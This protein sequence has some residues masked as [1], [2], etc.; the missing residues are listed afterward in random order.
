MSELHRQ[1]PLLHR[2]RRGL[3]AT[4]GLAAAAS[5]L[6]LLGLSLAQIVA[7]NL[8]DAGLPW[9]E[10]ASRH[11]VLYVLFFGALLAVGSRRH[12]K[13]DLLGAW[14]S[15]HRQAR[16]VRPLSVIAAAVC[17]MLG[18]AAVRY[19]ID[20]WTH[21]GADTLWVTLMDLVI[22]LGFALMSLQFL[23]EAALG[24]TGAPEQTP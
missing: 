20:A 8:L 6:A 19:W 10:T 15:P 3:L 16:L 22:P 11:L 7:R 21:G 2:I 24:Q 1:P 14:L 17:A 9:A 13:I 23:L 4:E 12:I 5:L 18:W